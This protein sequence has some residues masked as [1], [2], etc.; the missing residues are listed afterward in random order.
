MRGV[1]VVLVAVLA[2]AFVVCRADAVPAAGG[3]PGYVRFEVQEAIKNP[4]PHPRLLATAA[5]FERLRTST[6]ELVRLGGERLLFEADQMR[7]FPLPTRKLEGRRM[8]TVSQ[9]ALSRI[10]TLS[11][12]YRLTG[13]S[14]YAARALAEAETV[15]GF[16]DWN[17]SHFLDTAEMTLAVAIAYD[18]LQDEMTAG[19]R[20]KLREGLVKLG[21]SEPNG[22][23]KTGG[24]ATAD[25]TWGQV[26][27]AGLSAGA[28][29]LMDEEPALAEE[30]LVRAA[31]AL[32]RPMKAFA[33]AGGFP[34][35]PA[36]YWPY[37]ME[38]NV[39]ALAAF[40]QAVG[41][42]FGLGELPGL[43]AS[44]DYLDSVTGPTGILFNYADA[45]TL[46]D[47]TKVALRAP[48]AASC[49][50][51]RRFNRADTLARFELPLYRAYCADRTPLNPTPRRAARRLLPLALLW[52]D[53]AAAS[54]P[55]AETPLCRLIPGR[56][57]IA[58]QRTGWARDDWFV[59][60]KGGSPSSPH[61]HMDGGSFVLDAKGVRWASD[62]GSDD[63]DRLEQAERNL[64][65]TAQNSDRWKIFR[66]GA[67]S[68]NVVRINKGLQYAG[69]SAL[70]V[71]FT[72]G[73]VS[74]AV[75]D[76]KS[77]YPGVAAATRTSTLIP[78]GGLILQDRFAG[79]AKGSVLRWQMVTPARVKSNEKNVLVLVQRGPGGEDVELELKVSDRFAR[80]TDEPLDSAPN[81]EEAPNPGYT[82][83]S[84][85][86]LAPESGTLDYS[87][88]FSAR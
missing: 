38:F 6:N 27:Q 24:W 7:T 68:H 88:L 79:M 28:I 87:V 49:W 18:W 22:A 74:K 57:P 60:L 71:A 32:P 44:A 78:G 12:A 16:K 45:G 75:L 52:L 72:N 70:F 41:T 66:L 26:C 56:V 9:R 21:L 35:G 86:L 84:F 77:L 42:D 5:D 25:N 37:A 73:P 33:P 1:P 53:P 8:L 15:C 67:G 51:A 10:L 34:E 19:Q 39:V 69:G 50:L 61:G 65:S 2:T 76:L 40:A 55:G 64:W 17:P 54:T 58:V 81:P 29:A 20:T 46:P 63:S 4:R 80:W 31:T 85:T 83:V 47:Q 11:F 48:S 43:R 23:V 3:W 59:G 13:S 36:A 62:L 14:R 82:L 30:I